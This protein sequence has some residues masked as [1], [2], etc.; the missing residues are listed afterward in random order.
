MI[1]AFYIKEKQVCYTNDLD[2]FDFEK[3]RI[4]IKKEIHESGRRGVYGSFHEA[5]TDKGKLGNGIEIEW[6]SY[7][8]T[9]DEDD[10]ILK[11]EGIEILGTKKRL[12]EPKKYSSI[13]NAFIGLSD[14]DVFDLYSKEL[15]NKINLQKQEID[16]LQNTKK[17]LIAD[18]QEIR[19]VLSKITIVTK[20]HQS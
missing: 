2:K 5:K 11:V 10:F 3:K 6:N 13:L 4:L 19:D 12:K 20:K 7:S 17:Q 18:V 9:E 14:M 15:K 1:E 16:N 8:G